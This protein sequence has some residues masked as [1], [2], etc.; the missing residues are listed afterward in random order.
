MTAAAPW[1]ITIIGLPG[2]GR[3]ALAAALAGRLDLARVE[4]DRVRAGMFGTAPPAA[5]DE[6]ALGGL[7][8]AVRALLADGRGCVVDGPT[9]AARAE[10]RY[11]QGLADIHAA[12][13]AAVSPVLSQRLAIERLRAR[14]EAAAAA[15]VRRAAAAM[16]PL[17]D[18]V[19]RI[20]ATMP[21]AQQADAVL[22]ALQAGI[23]RRS[24]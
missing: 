4:L 21:P 16:A 20:D 22:A 10:R 19:L 3:S 17:E 15:R 23:A 1:L 13:F 8:L 24:L 12:R 18:A 9:F 6:A 11:A 7:W 14:G 5:A 2:S